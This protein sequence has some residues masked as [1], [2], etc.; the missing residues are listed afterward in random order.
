MSNPVGYGVG[1]LAAGSATSQ[2]DYPIG[3]NLL[4]GF[5]GHQGAAFAPTTGA[6]RAAPIIGVTFGDSRV[7]FNTAV[8]TSAVIGNGSFIRLNR[9]P[10]WVSA[11]RGDIEWVGNYGLSGDI[12]QPGVVANQGW[13]TTDRG[14]GKTLAAALATSGVQV[15]LIQYGINSLR[16]WNGTSPSYSSMLSTITQGLQGLIGRLV[17]AGIKVIYESTNSCQPTGFNGSPAL[18]LQMLQ[19]MNK[20]M[21]AYCQ[22]LRGFVLYVDTSPLLNLPNGYFNQTLWGEDD[23]HFN[24]R[25]A[26]YSATAI[27]NATLDFLPIQ[28]G[29]MFVNSNI[30]QGNFIN[31]LVPAIFTGAPSGAWNLSSSYGIDSNGEFYVEVQAKPIGLSSGTAQFYVQINGPVGSNGATPDYTVATSDVVQSGAKVTLDDGAGGKPNA[32]ELRLSTTCYYQAGG[33]TQSSWGDPN[34]SISPVPADIPAALNI[35]TA[36]TPHALTA[37]S[38][39]IEGPAQGKGL[40]LEAY[41]RSSQIG[42]PVR[43]R[44]TSPW[45]TKVA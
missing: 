36:T 15:A 34:A 27:A 10:G 5:P 14:P 13:S 22:T 43:L 24:T 33:S 28:R 44:L 8:S 12:V 7:N 37:G 9:I 45:L 3:R 6:F 31:P 41:V 4:L 2:G 30:R 40:A 21:Q 11:L 32:F 26:Q 29:T 16:G 23:T 42:L 19:D 38:A 39:G 25:G 1:N 18:K 17:G 35:R 20:I